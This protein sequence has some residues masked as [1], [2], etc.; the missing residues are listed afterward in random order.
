MCDYGSTYVYF[1]TNVHP[2]R[3]SSDLFYEPG[4]LPDCLPA[5]RKKGCIS[6]LI[7]MLLG[8]VGLPVFSG[9]TGSIISFSRP[10]GGYLVGFILLA[11]IMELFW[12]KTNRNIVSEL[13]WYG[14]RNSNCLSV[15]NSLVCNRAQCTVGYTLSV[16]VMPFYHLI[17]S[18]W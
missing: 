13:C 16:C 2:D 3:S 17:Y 18:R 5:W 10:T 12:K 14:S 7:Y 9:Y 4:N 8:V 6:Y 11:L 15:W 1:R